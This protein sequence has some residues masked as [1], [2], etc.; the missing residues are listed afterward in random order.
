MSPTNEVLPKIIQTCSF[1]EALLLVNVYIEISHSNGIYYVSQ[2]HT[3]LYSGR[4]GAEIAGWGQ[5]PA[6]GCQRPP[7]STAG[8][9]SLGQTSD[10][11]FWE[12]TQLF[13]QHRQ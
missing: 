6:M 5:R 2:I 8:Q 12:K 3:K 10:P 1:K 7:M 13:V 9:P 11:V 4:D